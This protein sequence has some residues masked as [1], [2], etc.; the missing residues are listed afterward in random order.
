MHQL[1]ITVLKQTMQNTFKQYY[2]GPVAFYNA[3]SG[4]DT[5]EPIWAARLA[6]LTGKARTLR[7][8]PFPPHLCG[9]PIRE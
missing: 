3:R 5:S 2:P 1:T 9:K 7:A 6:V 4:N 8:V